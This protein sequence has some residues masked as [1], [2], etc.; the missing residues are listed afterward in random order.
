M[1]RTMMKI[2]RPN[3]TELYMPDQLC[4]TPVE[5]QKKNIN[6]DAMVARLVVVIMYRPGRKDV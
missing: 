3:L 2:L 5:K 6:R 4:K 1:Q